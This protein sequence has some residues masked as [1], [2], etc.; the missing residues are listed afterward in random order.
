MYVLCGICN[1]TSYHVA[2]HLWLW[3][4]LVYWLAAVG[5]VSPLGPSLYYLEFG[6][7]RL[8]VGRLRGMAV[9]GVCPL[10]P[11]LYYL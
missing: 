2:S 5:R 7:A 3:L 1:G 6:C 11:S 8:G 4:R 9:G 10:G